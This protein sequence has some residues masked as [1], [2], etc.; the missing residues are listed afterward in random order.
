MGA[1]IVAAQKA[2]KNLKKE[3]PD[4]WHAPGQKASGWAKEG[5]GTEE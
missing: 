2:S 4:F 1:F 3:F 5:A